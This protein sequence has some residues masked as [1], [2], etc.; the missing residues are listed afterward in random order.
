[1]VHYRTAEGWGT[2]EYHEAASDTELVAI[3]PALAK[4]AVAH[5]FFILEPTEGIPAPSADWRSEDAWCGKGKERSD[6]GLQIRPSYEETFAVT[7]KGDVDRR[8]LLAHVLCMMGGI[9]PLLVAAALAAVFLRTGKFVGAMRRFV[10]VGFVLLLLGSVP[11]GIALEYQV[12][13]TYWEGWPFGRDVTDTKSGL[14][15]LLWLGL[16]LSRG[17]WVFSRGRASGGLSDEAW[18]KLLIAL[19]VFT[20]AIYLIPHQNLRF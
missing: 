18:A 20:F 4:S 3:L 16:I 9:V 14:M 2:A 8:L 15:L 11:L 7:Y 12:F 10:L 1:M 19:S 17:R 5:F 6:D 13:G